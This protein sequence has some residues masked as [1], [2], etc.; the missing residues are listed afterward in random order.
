MENHD[1]PIPDEQSVDAGAA[2]GRELSLLENVDRTFDRAVGLLSLPP[3]LAEQIKH[4]NSVI[5][6]RFPVKLESGR[7]RVFTG[8]R[9]LH[10]AHRLPGK[11][12]I[13]YAPDVSEFEI[14]ALAALMSYKCALV[15]VP[16]S[17]SKGGV[18]IDP[19]E[20]SVNDLEAVTR[21]LARELVATG[22][23]SPGLKVPAPDLGTTP[24]EM[25][26][27][28][29]TY[30][31]LRSD[32]INA[33]A[34][35]TG[36]PERHGGIAGRVEATGRGLQYGLRELF[37]HPRD[38]ERIG[39]RAGSSLGDQRV[40]VQ[41]LGNVGEHVARF[42][43]EDDGC[44]VI[45]VIERDGGLWDE[46]GL[47]VGRVIRHRRDTGGLKGCHEGEYVADGP[48]LLEAPCDILI[49]AATESQITAK[50][51]AGIRAPLIAEAAN[52]PTTFAADLILR[53]RGITVLQDVYLN[54]GGVMVSYLEWVKN[55]SHMRFGRLDRRLQEQRGR[56]VI[57]AIEGVSGVPL[58]CDLARPLLE[59]SGELDRVRAG[60]D[61][62][63]RE[64]YQDIR[65]TQAR[66]P[67]ADDLRTAA[68]ALAIEKIGQAYADLGLV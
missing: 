28:S 16:F 40:V 13:R 26:W 51:A 32:D 8:W 22:F 17:G 36:K 25:G 38:L 44:R 34:C 31:S 11:G 53:E 15:D 54:A 30:R 7:T 27:I 3:G 1:R 9:A 12:G 60:L 66:L 14:E 29:D 42:L 19:A 4:C 39:L 67:G 61:D 56:E 52:G 5:Q 59:G 47:H 21:R 49:P 33:V 23:L 10:S 65:E 43:S 24:R 35:V 37:R 46:E 2:A 41:G 45:G 48:S 18:V 50:N 58:S 68:F 63:M 20:T 64:A 6:L 57:R 62:T 55:V